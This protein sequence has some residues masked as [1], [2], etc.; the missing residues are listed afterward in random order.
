MICLTRAVFSSPDISLSPPPHP[1][2]VASAFPAHSASFTDGDAD[3]H[4]EGSVARETLV[5]SSSRIS[6]GLDASCCFGLMS[7][8]R[9]L[10]VFSSSIQEPEAG[11]G[12]GQGSRPN[13]LVGRPLDLDLRACCCYGVVDASIWP[14]FFSYQGNEEKE[15]WREALQPSARQRA[16]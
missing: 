1:L 6:L 2:R 10:L 8:S 14:L 7:V 11:V 15:W 9:V 5:N 12:P 4:G 3:R 13:K 16:A